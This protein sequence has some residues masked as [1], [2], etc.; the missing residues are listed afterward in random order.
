MA[1]L[2]PNL[3]IIKCKWLIYINEKTKIG[4]V[5]QKQNTTSKNP[6]EYMMCCPT[7]C[8]AQ[9][10]HLKYNNIDRVKLKEWKKICQKY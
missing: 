8:C 1:D 2:S 9:V 4:R 6:K 10:T 3:S 7:M 5:A